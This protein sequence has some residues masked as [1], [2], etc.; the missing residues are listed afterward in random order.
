MSTTS[1]SGLSHDVTLP[2]TLCETMTSFLANARHRIIEGTRH[3]AGMTLSKGTLTQYVQTHKRVMEYLRA[4][5]IPDIPLDHLGKE[6]YDDLLHY[7]MDRNFA[8]NTI[9][10]HVKNIKAMIRV[11]PARITVNCEFVERGKCVKL[12]EDINNVVLDEN[13]LLTLREYPFTGEL[14]KVR[15]HFLLLC[16][17]GCRYSDLDKL[18]GL[19]V[20]PLGAGKV[21]RFTQQKTGSK[22]SIPIFEEIVPILEK[23]NYTPDPPLANTHFN[24]VLKDVCRIAGLVENIVIERTQGGQRMLRRCSKW[25]A[26]TA[27][28]AR[29][30]FATNLY[31]RGYPTIAIMRLTGHKTEK[32]FLRYIKI[33]EDQ[34]ALLILNLIQEEKKGGM[35]REAGY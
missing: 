25:E 21:F 5:K 7:F 34:N 30:T 15:D 10:K 8:K 12:E 9:G 27:H 20:Y 19:N 24:R 2:S 14:E 4:R 11:L 31:R 23:Y 33:D 3:S 22:V 1:N 18:I 35:G 13:E 6:F 29:R 17:T 16:W 26:V 32:S 28:T